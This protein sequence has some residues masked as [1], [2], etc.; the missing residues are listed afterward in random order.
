MSGGVVARKKDMP[1]ATPPVTSMTYSAFM[2]ITD[3]RFAPAVSSMREFLTPYLPWMEK[4]L[5]VPI[6]ETMT[7][8]VDQWERSLCS[9]IAVSVLAEASIEY[10]Q[11]EELKSCIESIQRWEL[12]PGTSPRICVSPIHELTSGGPGTW[13]A[14]WRECPVA[15]WLR[16]VS[17]PIIAVSIPYTSPA[18]GLS[19]AWK[20]W[21][22]VPREVA[23]LTLDALSPIFNRSSR[24]MRVIGGSSQRL[25]EECGLWDDLVLEPE[26][27]RLV[28]RDFES[29]F[30]RKE[31]FQRHRLPFKRGYLFYGPPGNGKTSVIRAMASRPHLA[32]FSV[33]FNNQEVDDSAISAMLEEARNI[34]PA[35]VVLEDLDRLFPRD[36]SKRYEGVK[37]SISGL[38]NGLDGIAVQQGLIVVATAND[39]SQLDP[40]I[41]NRPGRFDR[42]V[43]FQNPGPAVRAKY[44]QQIGGLD[45]TEAA[46]MMDPTDGFSFAHL[47]ETYILSGQLAFE[48]DRD[49]ATSDLLQAAKI[50]REQSMKARSAHGTKAGFRA[51]AV[52]PV[53]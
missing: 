4:T 36:E 51:Y 49:I 33:N 25:E 41:F 53:A 47:R 21:L 9:A 23:N 3:I 45:A 27:Q 20:N 28:Q 7:L 11:R 13:S 46:K 32:L 17:S 8:E 29:F 39:P 22:I 10:G 26:I 12:P 16:G 44:F 38:L 35:L 34:A 40:A 19:S 15:L 18:N 37:V 6:G 30:A 42:V 14:D 24:R 2:M 48:A 52:T 43:E 31:W 5:G 1:A 50:M